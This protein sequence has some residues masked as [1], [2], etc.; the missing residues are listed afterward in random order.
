MRCLRRD[1]ILIFIL[2]LKVRCKPDMGSR[3]LLRGQ[4]GSK[5]NLT[6]KRKLISRL[7][8]NL[9]MKIYFPVQMYNHEYSR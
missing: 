9:M 1:L 4:M 7:I 5:T 3:Q 8:M 2:I 6:D